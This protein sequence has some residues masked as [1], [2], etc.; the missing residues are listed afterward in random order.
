MMAAEER[1]TERISNV[2]RYA[3]EDAKEM[4][5][6]EDKKNETKHSFLR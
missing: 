1:N 4:K 2:K 5:V 6:E 3:D